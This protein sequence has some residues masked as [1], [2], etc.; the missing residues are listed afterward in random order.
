MPLTPTEAKV[1]LVIGSGTALADAAAAL[2]IS[3][4]TLKTHGRRIYQKTDMRGQPE[5][6][7]LMGMLVPM[8]VA[9]DG[10]S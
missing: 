2:G 8:N 10:L 5:L 1:A 7:Q 9:S 6:V 3:V 4:T